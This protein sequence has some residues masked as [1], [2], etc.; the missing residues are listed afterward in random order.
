MAKAKAVDTFQIKDSYQ[1]EFTRLYNS[2]T[3]RHARWEVWA[4]FIEM[5][6]IEISSAVDKTH[7]EERRKTYQMIAGKYTAKEKATMVGMLAQ[8]EMGMEHDQ[9]QDFLG[10]LFMALALGNEHNGQFFT[11]YSVCQM[12]SSVTADEGTVQAQLDKNGWISCCDPA[13]GAGALLVAFANDCKRKNI[14][15]HDKVLFVAQ[16]IDFITGLMCYI[17]L[18]FLG[19]PGYVVIENTLTHPTT[20]YDKRGLLPVDR[21]NVWYTPFYFTPIW[22]GRKLAA[23]MDLFL[24]RPA[25]NAAEQ[26]EALQECSEEA[27]EEKAQNPEQK[28]EKTERKQIAPKPDNETER[29]VEANKTS[30][31]TYQ[32]FDD[33][34]GQLKLF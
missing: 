12:M 18:T 23:R 30:E 14:V 16:D 9:D 5:V 24:N 29:F 19:C 31:P 34:A 1:R 8:I 4:D 25:K 15:Y 11:P 17:Q 20:S 13:C 22:E 10:E 28:A 26:V 33:G 6:A 21:G 27:T 2:L 7:L 32:V 3:D